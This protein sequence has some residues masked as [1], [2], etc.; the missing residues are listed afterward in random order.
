M[1][2]PTTIYS[3][4][5]DSTRS[6][7]LCDPDLGCLTFCS[8]VSF[9]LFDLCCW[10]LF[11]RFGYCVINSVEDWFGSCWCVCCF[12]ILSLVC[13]AICWFDFR[14]LSELIVMIG[15]VSLLAIKPTFGIWLLGCKEAIKV[16]LS[17]ALLCFYYRFY[18]LIIWIFFIKSLFSKMLSAFGKICLNPVAP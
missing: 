7:C 17:A 10:F 2:P 1:P 16:Y 12:L 13:W 6:F 18:C 3:F 5:F 11:E 14:V 15:S 4:D 9:Y 8:S